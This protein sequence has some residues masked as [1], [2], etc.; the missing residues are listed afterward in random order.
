MS[1]FD[2]IIVGAGSAGCVLAN[3]LSE[4]PGNQ[5]L[6]LEAGAPDKKMEIK[7]PGAYTRLHRSEVDWG[8]WSEPQKQLGGRKLFLPRGK[9]LGGSSSTNAMVYVR[10][11]RADYDEWAALGNKGWNYDSVLPYFKKSEHNED[12]HN[13]FHGDSGP[14]NVT[15]ARSFKTPF[16]D[17]FVEACAEKGIPKNPDYNGAE[18]AG[19]SL[20][21]FTIKNGKRHST[22]DA[23]LKPILKRSNLTIKTHALVTE[24][25]LKN[26]RAIGVKVT[27]QNGEVEKIFARKEVT[28]SAGAFKSPQILLLSG[29]GD[30]EEL[31]FFGI[32]SR[33]SLLGVGKNLQDHLFFNCSALSKKQEG[34]N[35]HTTP[36]NQFK[37]LIQLFLSQK[38]PLTCSPLEAVA[39][40]NSHGNKAVDFQ[41]QFAPIQLGSDY[42]TDFHDLATFPRT[43]GYTIL[44]SLIKPKSKG[45]ISLKNADPKSPPLIQPNFLSEQEDWDTLIRG[46]KKAIEILESAAFEPFCK[47]IITPPDRSD[48]GI[49]SHIKKSVETIYHPV[50]TCKMGN[51]ELAVV[52]H[53]LR[54]HGISNL[55]IAD[56]SIMPTIV[57]GNTN[58]SCIMI[59]EKAA[60]LILNKL[61]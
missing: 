55:R 9:T 49:I 36:W 8:F 14:L 13:E 19:A 17:A 45:F 22:A 11:N 20:F 16:A 5:V 1:E 2:Y 6:L 39:F 26:D 23:F 38:G 25:I 44:P 60:D 58:A 57:S 4:D 29:I 24:V 12:I 30:P 33:I 47:Q 56:A 52:D 53:E 59:G 51:D 61:N 54:V 15:F 42:K 34:F 48:E 32:E 46:C 50:G 27:R 10:G 28:L 40:F 7:I 31:K 21:Q 18:Q 37:G 43:D 35:H 41:F 3:R